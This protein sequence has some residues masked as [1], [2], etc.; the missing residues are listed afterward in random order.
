MNDVGRY[1]RPGVKPHRHIGSEA[2]FEEE[3]TSAS[4]GLVEIRAALA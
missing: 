3:S 4:A 1:S 2:G